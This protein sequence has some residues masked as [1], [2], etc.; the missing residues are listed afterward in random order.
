MDAQILTLQTQGSVP[1]IWAL[2]DSSKTEVGRTFETFGTGE[3]FD[4][5]NMSYVGTFQM[6]NG[7]LIFHLFEIL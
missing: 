3:S 2:C 5:A 7:S 4:S 6:H 1:T